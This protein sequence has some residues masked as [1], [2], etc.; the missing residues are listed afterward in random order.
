MEAG[1]LF[2]VTLNFSSVFN[3]MDKIECTGKIFGTTENEETNGKKR[4]LQ[5]AKSL[6]LR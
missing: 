6:L 5:K 3:E 2:R 4:A 1:I